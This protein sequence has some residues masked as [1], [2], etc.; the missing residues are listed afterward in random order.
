MCPLQLRVH[1]STT[2]YPIFSSILWNWSSRT[3]ALPWG[4]CLPCNPLKWIYFVSLLPPADGPITNSRGFFLSCPWKPPAPMIRW[5]YPCLVQSSTWLQVTHYTPCSQPLAQSLCPI[6][7]LLCFMVTSIA[8][9]MALPTL[10]SQFLDILSFKNLAFPPQ[11]QHPFCEHT[12][13][14]SIKNRCTLAKGVRN[15][16]LH[17]LSPTASWT[18]PSQALVPTSLLKLPLWGSLMPSTS[19]NPVAGAFARLFVLSLMKGTGIWFKKQLS[20]KQF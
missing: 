19:P 11:P 9:W 16:C 4:P 7:L 2:K 18:P 5:Y 14:L 12:L 15:H 8:A 1:P 3:L 6:L 13:G 10:V 17:F 20:L